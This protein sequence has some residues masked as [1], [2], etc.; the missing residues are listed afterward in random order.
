MAKNRGE[1]AWCHRQ[2]RNGRAQ[3]NRL[4]DPDSGN[5]T[6]ETLQRAAAILGRAVRVE[7]V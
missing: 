7:L 5:V 1:H 2:G 4:L 6:L 3:L